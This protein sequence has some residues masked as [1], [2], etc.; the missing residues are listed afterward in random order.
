MKLQR[1]QELMNHEVTLDGLPA[2]VIGRLEKFATVRATV[3]SGISVEFAW[4]TVEHII[5][6]KAG[7]FYS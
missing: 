3:H 7:K 4:E 5:M 6:N 2:R 1:K